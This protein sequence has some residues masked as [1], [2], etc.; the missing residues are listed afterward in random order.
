[1][2]VMKQNNEVNQ[3]YDFKL[4]PAYCLYNGVGVLSQN[5]A[6][7]KFLL[8]ETENQ[9]LK[10][11]ISRAFSNY[12]QLI[13][14]YEDCPEKYKITPHVEFI[15]SSHSE[16]RKFVSNLYSLEMEENS[17]VPHLQSSHSD[18]SFLPSSI[19]LNE[20]KENKDAA[21]VLLLDTILFEARA[22]GATDIHIE[23]NCVRFRIN[24]R[25]KKY[26]VLQRTAYSELIQRIKLLS[27]M[28]VMEKHHCQDGHFSWDKNSPLFVRVSTACVVDEKYCVIGSFLTIVWQKSHFD[29]YYVH[30]AFALYHTITIRLLFVTVHLISHT[31]LYYT[32]SHR[33]KRLSVMLCYPKLTNCV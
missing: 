6:A 33:S 13:N 20:K 22:K 24:G 28:N 19:P 18:S 10:D 16:I 21:A 14:R 4:T 12:L 27:D 8:E 17:L 15:K 1:M 32:R 2:F 29:T 23:N 9:T 3:N 5:G 25:L 11:R 7:I 30:S 31:L 26:Q